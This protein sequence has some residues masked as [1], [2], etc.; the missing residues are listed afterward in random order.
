[1]LP[2]VEEDEDY[3]REAGCVRVIE[4]LDKSQCSMAAES[5]EWNGGSAEAGDN[6]VTHSAIPIAGGSGVWVRQEN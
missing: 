5:R 4:D 6:C 1:M 2:N 3:S